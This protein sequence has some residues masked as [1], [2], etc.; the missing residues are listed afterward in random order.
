[1]PGGLRMQALMGFLVLIGLTFGAL[2]LVNHRLMVSQAHSVY[3]ARA[4][5][6]VQRHLAGLP[7]GPDVVRV[8]A[9][10]EADSVHLDGQTVDV[11][12]DGWRVTLEDHG[13]LS[14]SQRLFVLFLAVVALVLLTFVYAL[15]TFLVVRPVRAIG[16]AAERA[17]DGDLASPISRLPPNEFG[18]VGESFNAMLARL[19]E[20]REELQRR[21]TALERANRQLETATASLVRSEKLAS[22]GQLAAG[23]A[24]EIGNPLAAVS[25]YNDLL[26][27]GGLEADD[28]RD[29]LER[30]RAQLLRIRQIIRKLL[31]FSRNETETIEATS[32][33]KCVGEAVELVGAL[34]RSKGVAF[35]VTPQDA[36]VHAA[37]A[38]LVQVLVN[39]MINAIDALQGVSHPT[40]R[41]AVLPG[42]GQTSVVVAD[43]GPGVPEN[44]R[45]RIFDPFFTT[46]DPGEGT[47]LGLAICSKILERAGATIELQG[48]TGSTFRLTLRT[49]EDA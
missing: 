2:A 19:N 16:L 37:P 32:V 15:F 25:G 28:Q 26:I 47:G 30:T 27:D 7:A 3:I 13:E 40:I 18:R 9:S 20:G 34:P 4:E 36:V 10:R 48:D 42:E 1:M 31:D 23:V 49:W 38:E 17:S 14:R 12:R 29:L 44:I 41:V 39:L 24:H 6:E 11:T 5:L 22:V 35:E 46:K 43:N 45:T 33:L 8:E 21:L